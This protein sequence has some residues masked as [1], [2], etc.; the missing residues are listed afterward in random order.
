M[1]IYT[2]QVQGGAVITLVVEKTDLL[3]AHRKVGTPWNDV[4]VAETV[5]MIGED[6]AFTAY[7]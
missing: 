4:V 5:R 2:L 6:P 7:I 1:G 3:T